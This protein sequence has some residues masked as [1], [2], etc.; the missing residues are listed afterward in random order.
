LQKTGEHAREAQLLERSE[1]LIQKSPRLGPWGYR[2]ADVQI[3]ALRGNGE[4]ALAK[5]REAEAAGWRGPYWRYYRD[6][7]PNLASIRNEPDFKAVFADIERDI[8]RQRA[9]LAARPKNVPR[10]D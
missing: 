3:D 7:D 4:L 9:A 6:F 5:L 8:A 1:A 2:L 10:S